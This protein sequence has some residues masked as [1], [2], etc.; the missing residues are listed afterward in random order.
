MTLASFW[1]PASYWLALH[2]FLLIA[3]QKRKSC[4]FILKALKVF[5]ETAESSLNENIS[6]Y[7]MQVQSCC[8]WPSYPMSKKSIVLV[9]L[10]L[11]LCEQRPPWGLAE[12][13][14][15]IILISAAMQKYSC[16]WWA[17]ARPS[18]TRW[19]LFDFWRLLK[20]SFGCWLQNRT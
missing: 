4:K 12:E 18:R 8:L 19:L 10:I 15:S 3:V 6:I 9:L 13:T 16:S 2:C 17:C 5:L 11:H 7:C 20:T 14:W 1:A